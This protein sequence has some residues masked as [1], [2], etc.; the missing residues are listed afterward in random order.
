[1]QP[2]SPKKTT[3]VLRLDGH[4]ALFPLLVAKGRERGW[5]FINLRFTMHTLPP[6]IRF[7]GAICDVLPAAAVRWIVIPST[8]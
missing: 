1:M 8:S 7:D 2:P 4:E 3:V 5:E 6:G